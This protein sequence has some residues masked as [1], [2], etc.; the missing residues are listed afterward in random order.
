MLL[1]GRLLARGYLLA[2]GYRMEK[3]V[4]WA[5][6]E[7]M[8]PTSIGPYRIV[9]ELGRGAM[10]I[11]WAAHDERIGRPV[12]IKVIQFSPGHTAE[13]IDELRRRFT[14]EAR[15]AGRLKHPGIV[16]IYDFNNEGTDPYLV[17]EYIDGPSLQQIAG[18]EPLPSAVVADIV[19]QTSAAL[20]YA[21][22]AGVIH[23]DVKPA[24]LL[25]TSDREVKLTDFGVA[26]LQSAGATKT[27]V[28]PG[29]PAYMSPEQIQS[30]RLDG[31]SDQ[32][33]LAV[34][35]Y[36]LLTGR[37]PFPAKEFTT[38]VYEI[39]H[40][41]PVPAH[42]VNPSL[43]PKIDAVLG[44]ALAK[45]PTKRYPT[46]AEFAQ[47][48][49]TAL[50]GA[51]EP[52]PDDS[53]RPQSPRPTHQF[54]RAGIV[55]VTLLAVLAILIPYL[56]KGSRKRSDNPGSSEAVV[57]LVT[58]Q[59]RKLQLAAGQSIEIPLITSVQ[60]RLIIDWAPEADEPSSLK[61][62]VILAATGG[63]GSDLRL[64]INEIAWFHREVRKIEGR[65]GARQSCRITNDG[66]PAA[67]EL[68]IEV[69]NESR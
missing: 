28:S 38:L 51:P 60:S 55:G 66:A 26:K 24:N 25:F 46:C 69:Q 11:V 3:F 10:G 65:M 2:S 40:E 49:T 39:L 17:L 27:T 15:A 52:A 53:P 30:A 41:E 7:P 16:T 50:T 48:L 42:S 44:R 68:A 59:V 32:F 20:D 8:T 36:R 13:E 14:L 21:H 33:S 31:R 56:F 62:S 22:R 35:A 63:S 47:A 4:R 23:R 9:R 12:A 19:S 34:V 37:L 45:N 58:G 61:G 54:R 57:P 6:A 29:T 43:P 5:C 1:T 18:N 67:I 64:A